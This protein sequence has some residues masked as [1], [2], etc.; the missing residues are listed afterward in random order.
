[1]KV[2]ISTPQRLL[3]I[4]DV[5]AES[6]KEAIAKAM[7]QFNPT[8][9]DERYRFSCGQTMTSAYGDEIHDQAMWLDTGADRLDDRAGVN[10]HLHG[11]GF[12]GE[13]TAIYAGVE[14]WTK[15]N[16]PIA[17]S[18]VFNFDDSQNGILICEKCSYRISVKEL[19]LMHA[20]LREQ[21]TEQ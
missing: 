7:S 3:D 21:I 8:L 6:E 12:N 15:A 19:T 1:M 18:H 9:P 11:L 5:S 17:C 10:G 4:V 13:M 20:V 14:V 16:L 2:T